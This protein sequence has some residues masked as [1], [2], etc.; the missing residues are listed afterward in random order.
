[1]LGFTSIGAGLHL[2]NQTKLTKKLPKMV[3][4]PTKVVFFWGIFRNFGSRR[5]ALQQNRMKYLK[6]K[7][8]VGFA[9]MNLS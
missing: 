6:T 1:M 7:E 8:K 9:V 3:I 2:S 4:L 5:G